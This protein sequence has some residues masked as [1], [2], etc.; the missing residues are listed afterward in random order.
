[1]LWLSGEL[2]GPY[3]GDMGMN[4]WEMPRRLSGPGH[5]VFVLPCGLR[6]PGHKLCVLPHGLGGPVVL[7]AKG[8]RALQVFGGGVGVLGVGGDLATGL[9][10]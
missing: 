3:W 9:S 2:L 10:D 8:T 5:N 4:V 7:K 6:G 1:M